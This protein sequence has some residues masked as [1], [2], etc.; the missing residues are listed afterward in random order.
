MDREREL[1][2]NDEAP[3][4]E[5]EVVEVEEVEEVGVV[6]VGVVSWHLHLWSV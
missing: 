6:V 4:V 3:K 1:K 2:D 5:V